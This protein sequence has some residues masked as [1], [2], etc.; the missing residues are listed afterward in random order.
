MLITENKAVLA[1]TIASAKDTVVDFSLIDQGSLQ[2]TYKDSTP[3]T[4]TCAAAGVTLLTNSFT[5]TA[6]TMVTGLKIT[7]L[8]SSTT[9]P[10]GLAGGTAY[11][12]IKLD[13]NTISL[14]ASLSDAIAGTAVVLSDVGVGTTTFTITALAGCVVK[15]QCSNDGVK[16]CDISGLTVSP[17]GSSNTSVM[18]DLVDKFYSSLRIDVACT[19]GQLDLTCTLF[20][21]KY[22]P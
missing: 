16:W 6:H 9:L 14:A 3:A 20:G 19:S 17:A 11:W 8:T 15:L 4:K 13:A 10:A 22:Y 1:T 7:G 18:W 21:K 12:V 2:V 5:I